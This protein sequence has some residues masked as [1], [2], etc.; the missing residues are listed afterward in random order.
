MK[1]GSQGDRAS[2]VS[3]D[4]KVHGYENLRVADLSVTPIL[5]RFVSTN[6]WVVT[7]LEG[8]NR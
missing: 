6:T 2:V 1:M 4:L 8:N 5:P 3:S 7:L